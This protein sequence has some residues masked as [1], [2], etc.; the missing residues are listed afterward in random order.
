MPAEGKPRNQFV[1]LQASLLTYS[2]SQAL[3]PSSS[4]MKSTSVKEHVSEIIVTIK[5][6]EREQAEE[7]EAEAEIRERADVHS[8]AL[9]SGYSYYGTAE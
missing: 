1:L 5:I 9:V 6:N 4:T 8:S 2:Y 3:S 7:R